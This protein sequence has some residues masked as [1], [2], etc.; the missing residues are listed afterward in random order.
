MRGKRAIL[1]VALL[2]TLATGVTAA[3]TTVNG[4]LYAH[5]MMDMS[6]GADS[7]NE[8][9]LSRA[10]VT[11]K[12]KL[13][14]YTSAR[15]TTDL[16]STDLDGSEVYNV[17][18]KYAYLDWKPA[19]ANQV[20]TLRFGLQPTQYF[21]AMNKMWGRRYLEKTVGDLNKFLTTSD[22][23][24]GLL[25]NL[26]SDG[27]VGFVAANIWN[28]TSYTDLEEMNKFK[29]FSGCVYLKP[30]AD[31]PDFERT[32]IL[33][34]AY[35]GTRN[36]SVGA[37]ETA[38]DW[39]RSLFSFGGL[40]AYRRLLDLGA[41]VNLYSEGQGPGGVD[42]KKAGYS[43]F[44]TIYFEDMGGGESLLR[45]LNLFGRMDLY[46][47]DTDV[48]DNAETLIIGGIECVPVKGFR[49]SVNLRHTSFQ[50]DSDPEKELYLN[51]LIKF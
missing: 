5:W 32:A 16:R 49:A 51:T 18:V 37:D 1:A 33:A 2:V 8:F 4:R 40:L 21:D 46:D 48:D 30:L 47:P 24:A 45:T 11:V 7:Y 31:N 41:D 17:I 44:G 50:D 6:E 28:G 26:D 19:F 27:K 23:G 36:V 29:D 13:S 43:F 34:Q 39:D 14:D 10:Y 38:S 20:V 9:G 12:S 3:E 22:L 35:F 25:V 15:I 42:T